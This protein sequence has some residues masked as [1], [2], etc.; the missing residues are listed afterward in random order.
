M[1]YAARKFVL[2]SDVMPKSTSDDPQTLRLFTGLACPLLPAIA[3]ELQLLQSAARETGSGLRVVKPNDLHLTLTFLGTCP[4]SAV[5]AITDALTAACHGSQPFTLTISGAGSFHGALWLGVQ[6]HALLDQLAARVRQSL[7]ASGL[8]SD[9]K[10]WQP[11]I[12]VARMNHK[13]RFDWKRWQRERCDLGFGTFVVQ[14]ALLYR[15]D[16]LAGG[17]RYSVLH[18]GRLG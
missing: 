1:V 9:G 2:L 15:S 7:A 16:T 12:T 6:P 13:P 5:A 8:V 3:D 14:E 18:R 11:H 4:V 17:A 10:H